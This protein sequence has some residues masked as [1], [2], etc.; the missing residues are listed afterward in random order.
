[1]PIDYSLL[2]PINADVIG[3]YQQ[4][5]QVAQANLQNAL[6]Q[7]NLIEQ[8]KRKNALAGIM[9]ASEG[10][11][12]KAIPALLQGGF[13]Q[14]AASLHAM[15]PKPAEGFSLTPGGARF[16]ASGRL[17]AQVPL[18]PKA[19]TPADRLARERFLFEQR[20][21]REEKGKP[22]QWN[23]VQTEEG[24]AQ[25]NPVT[26][27]VRKL[28]INPIGKTGAGTAQT[29][30]QDAQDAMMILQQAAPLIDKSTHSGV[31]ALVDIGAGAFGAST[32]GAIAA[33]QLKVLGGALVSKMPKMSGPQSD[34][35]V[36]LYKEMAGRIGDPTVP[37]ERKKAAM[38]TIMELQSKYAGTQ[39]LPLEFGAKPKANTSQDSE[40]I[41][42]AKSNPTDPRAAKILSLHGM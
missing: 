18:E 7:R 41:A 29:R 30:A 20:K 39:P 26:G 15:A 27:E 38:Q 4:G 21:F 32:P 8:E 42:W 16:D 9:A 24:F 28:G 1:M 6:A 22:I 35:D 34:K 33:D 5:T 3:S 36:Q 12:N 13:T 19:E 23:T 40:A 2:K 31:G 25:V 11:P 17:I 10:D 14:E 37:A